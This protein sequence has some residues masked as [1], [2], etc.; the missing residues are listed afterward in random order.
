MKYLIGILAN[1]AIQGAS[2][3]LANTLLSPPLL[4]AGDA[5]LFGAIGGGLGA[6]A[7]L[8]II[9]KKSEPEVTE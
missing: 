3:I 9:T 2:L 6:I 1:I 7:M 5:W 8:N 4:V